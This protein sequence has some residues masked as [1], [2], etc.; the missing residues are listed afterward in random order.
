MTNHPQA[1]TDL[2]CTEFIEVVTAYL[3]D[4]VDVEQRRR[5]DAHLAGC[6]GCTAALGQFRTVIDLSG[7]LTVADVANLD[8]LVRDRLEAT[9]RAPRRK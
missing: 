7:R 2:R 4:A 3:D 6:V 1:E 8:P 5:I 9:L